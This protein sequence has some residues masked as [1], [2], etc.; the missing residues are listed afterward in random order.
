MG[1]VEL[2]TPEMGDI[3]GARRP[4]GMLGMFRAAAYEEHNSAKAPRKP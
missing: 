3:F 1:Q 4:S 2:P